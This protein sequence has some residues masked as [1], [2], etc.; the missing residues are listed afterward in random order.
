MSIPI[1]K[2]GMESD[3]S[4]VTYA[5]IEIYHSPEECRAFCKWMNGQTAM[6]L[7]SG[8]TGIYT[9]DYERWLGEGRKTEQNPDTWD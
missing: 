4:Y 1:E 5:Q 7:K 9:W 8:E 6:L 3:I 2:Y